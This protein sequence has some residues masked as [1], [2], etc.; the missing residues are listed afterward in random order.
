MALTLHV[1]SYKNNAPAAELSVTVNSTD[2]SIGR[3]ANNDLTLPD[4]ERIVSHRHAT[5][6][7]ENDTYYL[8]DN[9]TNGT[10]VNHGVEPVGQGKRVALHN[11]D[12][13]SIGKYDCAISISLP[14]IDTPAINTQE[15]P[16]IIS[17]PDEAMWQPPLHPVAE[18][19]KPEL[20]KAPYPEA[21]SPAAPAPIA[22]TA[23]QAQ[24]AEQSYFQPPEAIREDW[25]ALT[26][27]M[28]KAKPGPVDPE[29]IIPEPVTSGS[30]I[31]QPIIAEPVTS[32]PIIPEPIIPE[33]IAAEPIAAQPAEFSNKPALKAEL[34]TAEKPMGSSPLNQQVVDAF[35]SGTGLTQVKLED[36]EVIRF[37]HSAGQLLREVTQG[38]RQILITRTSLKGEFRLGMTTLQPSENNPVKFSIDVDDALTKL[39]F[40]PEKG[41]L[42]PLKAIQEATDDLQA[43]QM[44]LLSGLRAALSSL[45]TLFDPET[46][47]KDLQHVS[48]VDNLL[49]MLKNAK[50]WEL[51]K[52]RYN[53]AAADAENDFLHALGSE[54]AIAYEQQIQRL[55]SSRQK[56]NL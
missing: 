54:F 19:K 10:Y 40:P 38:F 14:A 56:N 8:T 41:Y 34:K 35:L 26:G 55:K 4:V 30:I 49:P 28:H 43:H 17:M 44:A 42:P 48:A 22:P 13:L 23:G 50:Y 33:P 32:E 53:E 9:S 52:T 31:P 25:D 45:I 27:L 37:M 18:E 1:T 47:E 2:C 20:I 5:I 39:L 15:K 24:A 11:D 51:F 21:G 12:V 6:Q 46:L 36:D 3:A 16:A 7:F 29:P